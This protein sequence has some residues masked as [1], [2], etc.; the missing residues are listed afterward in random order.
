MNKDYIQKIVSL[1]LK[2][3]IGRGD[4]TTNA[5]VPKGH[6]SRA[7]IVLKSR[8]VICGLD[9]AR[10][11]FAQLDPKIRFQAL[12][13]DGQ[14][15]QSSAVIAHVQGPG[16]AL[17]MGERVAIN[18]LSYLSAIATKTSDFVG[19]VKPYK[20]VILDTRK[21]TPTLREL[22]RYAVRCGGGI[23]HRFD[24]SQMAMVKDNH[25]FFMQGQ[26]ALEEA[27]NAVQRASKK[28]VE[29]EVDTLGQLEQALKTKADIILLDNMSP[30]QTRRAVKRR[31]QLKSMA[32]LES[33][34]R[35]NLKTVR[36]YAA[37][38]VDRI[39][40][41]ELTHSRQVLDISLEFCR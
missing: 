40:V 19:A 17:L 32:L 12:V 5:L 37:T 38:G 25:R 2:E 4:I 34:G 29:L 41:G 11:A 28:P 20:T 22:E 18:F 35:I 8:G 15:V 33:S 9:F 1:A 24:L 14:S 16:R 39:S 26:M 30:A 13:H 21:T 36:Q 31:N 10:Q 7:R 27:I 3:D 23:N 6:R